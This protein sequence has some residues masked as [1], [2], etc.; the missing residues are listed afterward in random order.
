M[1][2]TTFMSFN[3]TGLDSAKIR[4]SLDLCKEYD[5]DFLA[6]QEHFKFVNVDNFFKS[7]Y[8]DYSSYVIPGHRSPGQMT[9]RAKGGIAQLCSRKYNVKRS[10]VKTTGF[11]L[12]AQVLETPSSR[13]LWINSYLPTDPQLQGYDDWELQELLVQVSNIIQSTQNDGIVWGSQLGS[14]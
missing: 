4:F 13:V 6:I 10:R 11:R 14:L 12:Q 9:G 5:V 1:D 7:G 3:T 8:V 2:S